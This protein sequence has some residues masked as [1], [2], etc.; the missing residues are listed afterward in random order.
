MEFCNTNCLKCTNPGTIPINFSG[1]HKACEPHYHALLNT[2]SSIETCL[3]C[4]SK[5]IIIRDL[6][7]F[8]EE[9]LGYNY[10]NKC[11]SLLCEDCFIEQCQICNFKDN[12]CSECFLYNENIL[13]SICSHKLCNICYTR[14]D[15]MCKRCS[16]TNECFN[17]VRLGGN[18][19]PRFCTKFQCE[20]CFVRCNICKN[21]PINYSASISHFC[22]CGKPLKQ[23]KC[24][25]CENKLKNQENYKPGNAQDVNQRKEP[26]Y[27]ISKRS[28]EEDEKKL[29]YSRSG[30]KSVKKES[31]PSCGK[32]VV[33]TKRKCEHQACATCV[34]DPCIICIAQGT[35]IPKLKPNPKEKTIKFKACSNCNSYTLLK[36]L[37]CSHEVCENCVDKKCDMCKINNAME[38]L[39]RNCIIQQ[40][41]TCQEWDEVTKLE[42]GHETCNNC[43]NRQCLQCER[44]RRSQLENEQNIQKGPD[45]SRQAKNYTE[46]FEDFTKNPI[47]KLITPKPPLPLNNNQKKKKNK[48]VRTKARKIPDNAEK[49]PMCSNLFVL[50]ERECKHLCCEECLK[51]MC[52][53]CMQKEICQSCEKLSKELYEDQSSHLICINCSKFGCRICK[54][55]EACS[56]CGN[57]NDGMNLSCECG[58]LCYN[59]TFLRDGDHCIL[60]KGE[61]SHCSDHKPCIFSMK[62]DLIFKE[63]KDMYFC[64]RCKEYVPKM[65]EKKKHKKCLKT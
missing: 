48:K 62:N 7:N 63:C 11:Q 6:C 5:V 13:I 30:E 52:K 22:K 35:T 20:Y 15:G 61:L 14:N 60:H 59:C 24:L 25:D 28:L 41:G 53:E 8:C 45:I 54:P 33:L 36:T 18:V 34:L 65:S 26:D 12:I 42:C 3:Y 29:V 44:D 47:P 37:E 56:N 27:K 40:C 17:C 4:I 46:D 43:K 57:F 50:I 2:K 16:Q 64:P 55:A 1:L 51:F 10:C 19:C 49:C 38:K 23:G 58:F 21:A 9:H 39:N 32:W 31:C